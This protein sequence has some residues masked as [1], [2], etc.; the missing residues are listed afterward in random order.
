MSVEASY[1]SGGEKTF[2]VRVLFDDDAGAEKYKQRLKN[3]FK[4]TKRW[5]D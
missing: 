4:V 2:L 1:T 3:K 5:S